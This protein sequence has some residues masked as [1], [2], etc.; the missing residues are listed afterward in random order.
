MVKRAAGFSEATKD[1]EFFILDNASGKTKISTR[2][3]EEVVNR[4]GDSCLSCHEK[5]E[6]QWDLVC[7]LDHGCDP[8]PINDAMIR[9]LQKTDPRCEVPA[10]LTEEEAEGLQTLMAMMGG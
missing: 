7:Q 8:I 9:A 1:W 2:G 10:E 6:P 3:H 5:A 4:F